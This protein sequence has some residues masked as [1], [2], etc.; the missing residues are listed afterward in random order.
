MSNKYLSFDRTNGLDVDCFNF[1]EKNDRGMTRVLNVIH[2]DKDELKALQIALDSG[3]KSGIIKM[4][5][6]EDE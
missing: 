4:D 1:C 6:L 2:L 3:K 5:K